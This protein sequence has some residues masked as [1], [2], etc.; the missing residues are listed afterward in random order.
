MMRNTFVCA[1]VVAAALPAAVADITGQWLVVATFDR[2][3]GGTRTQPRV[4][5][6]CTFEQHEA[7]LAGSCRPADA[8]EGLPITGTAGEKTVEWSFQIAP[9][10][11]A[12][13]QSAVFR[14]TRGSGASAMSG[15][16]E[17]GESHGRFRATKQ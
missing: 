15:R 9:N 14:G 11:T 13:R 6:V 4:E 12:A 3:T 7:A 17:F 1:A 5:L 8:P 2:A 16:F 10:A